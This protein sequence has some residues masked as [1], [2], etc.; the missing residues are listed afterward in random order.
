MDELQPAF[1]PFC[2]PC[3]RKVRHYHPDGLRPVWPCLYCHDGQHDRCDVYA[4]CSCDCGL[5]K[6]DQ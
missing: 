5:N 3:I 1:D 6:G 2:T 4:W